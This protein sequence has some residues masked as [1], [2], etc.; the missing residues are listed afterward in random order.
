MH[1][2]ENYD[3]RSFLTSER[4]DDSNATP[5]STTSFF[6]PPTLEI[7]LLKGG[8]A[9]EESTA[10]GPGVAAGVGVADGVFDFEAGFDELAVF[11]PGRTYLFAGL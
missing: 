11:R 5:P 8:A 4:P 3:S 2:H 6:C 1:K 7:G 9:A 10:E